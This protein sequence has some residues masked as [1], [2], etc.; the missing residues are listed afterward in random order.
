VLLQTTLNLSQI[1]EAGCAE[2]SQPA[3]YLGCSITVMQLFS[4]TE[5]ADVVKQQ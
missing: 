4:M 2:K 1:D 3:I 5:S